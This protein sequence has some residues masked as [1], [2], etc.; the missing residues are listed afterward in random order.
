MNTSPKRAFGVTPAVTALAVAALTLGAGA[1]TV[2]AYGSPKPCDDRREAP[3]FSP[4]G[5]NS[6]YFRVPNG[7][8]EFGAMNWDLSD[9]ATVVSGNESYRVAG[10]GGRSL[11]IPD[12]ARA[13]SRTICVWRGEDTVRLFV[14]SPDVSGAI[15]HIEAEV[16]NPA[17]G[18]V[19]QRSFD[20]ESDAAD[21]W[22]PT[23]RLG[24]PN[25]LGGDDDTQELTLT[26]T[27]RGAAATW[28]IDD[29]YVDPYK[30]Y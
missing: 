10:W 1:T 8:F 25:L 14:K 2:M 30:S 11:S 27:T 19:S 22:A 15:L 18:E 7:G 5:D 21:D 24:I 12:G 6:S 16:E 29:V 13:E 17:T 4:W 9:G 20:V 26:F 3:V 28:H 23:A